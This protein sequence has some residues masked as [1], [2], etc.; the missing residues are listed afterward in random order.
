[1]FILAYQKTADDL[2]TYHTDHSTSLTLTIQNPKDVSHENDVPNE[3]PKPTSLKVSVQS[4]NVTGGELLISAKLTDE[5]GSSLA[6]SVIIFYINTKIIRRA[7]NLKRV[8]CQ[9]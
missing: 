7:V 5:N 8:F 9:F 1:M 6:R 3:S 4:L 2:K